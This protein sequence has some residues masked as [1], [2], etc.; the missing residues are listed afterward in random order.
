MKEEPENHYKIE[1]IIGKGSFASVYRATRLIDKSS[2]AIKM[3]SIKRLGN[4]ALSA[5]LNEIRIL[6][7]LNCPYIVK[8]HE[9]FID[10]SETQLWIVMELLEGGD[11]AE[12]INKSLLT[13]TPIR[14]KQIWIYFIQALMGLK[15]LNH[16]GIIHRDI[17]PN[18]IFL[19][20]DKKTIKIGDM[21][22]SKILDK[23]FTRTL[24]GSPG[25]IAPEVWRS[26][27]HNLSCDSFALGCAIFELASGHLP[28]QAE[29]LSE[30][31][32]QILAENPRKLPQQYSSELQI[33]IGRCLSKFSSL[34]PNATQLLDDV[35]V[36]KKIRELCI[37]RQKLQESKM[38]GSFIKIP[39][40][41][42]L[43]NKSLPNSRPSSP[44]TRSKIE[45]SEKSGH[46]YLNVLR[47]VSFYSSQTDGICSSSKITSLQSIKQTSLR[48]K[49]IVAKNSI[50][51]DQHNSVNNRKLFQSGIGSADR[52]K[53]G[54]PI[55]KFS[56]FETYQNS[57]SKQMFCY[58]S[59]AGKLQ[60][61]PLK[62]PTSQNGDL[63]QKYLT[64][65]PRTQSPNLRPH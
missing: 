7:S 20:G 48:N 1:N 36:K 27:P 46:T 21:N 59:L 33:I 57:P 50:S 64:N 23:T 47:D 30:M 56:R 16:L 45:V 11:L 63:S 55:F 44:H 12:L 6:S 49:Q 3:I 31:K 52:D 40:Q 25:Y 62:I 15:S 2:V 8:Y 26:Q 24:V 34:R 14:E 17:K 32:A 19:T 22:A 13:K 54:L 60:R 41:R 58:E 4:A 43:L 61:S 29:S 28:F 10:K 37:P 38:V 18:N 53:N 5:A 35:L 42:V 51:I 65:N 9:S 39:K